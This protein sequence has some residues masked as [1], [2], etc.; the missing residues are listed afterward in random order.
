MNTPED[1]AAQMADKTNDQ[2]LAMFNRPDD[3][4]SAALDAG[5][6]ELQRRG[7]EASAL[8]V[9]PPPMQ[10]GQP[11]FFPVSTL[12]LVVMSTVT[13]GIYEI[14]WFYINWK[15][16]KQ[17]TDSDIMPFWRAL[18]GVFF[19]YSFFRAVKDEAVARGISFP[20]SPGLLAAGWIILTF[21]W[22]LP[23]PYWFVC[24]LAPLILV[25]VQSVINR[26]NTVVDPMHNQRVTAASNSGFHH[27]LR[28]AG[29]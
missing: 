2:L 10:E 28:T 12:K 29:L 1:L 9:G 26:L 22:R 7:I 17:R 14:Y 20:S 19:C 11:I 23:D 16:I 27:I 25:A 8:P 3:W 4:L 24:F 21:L 15:F 6:A 18:F 5:R 13:F